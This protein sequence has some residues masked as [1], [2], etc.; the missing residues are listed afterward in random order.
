MAKRP[1]NFGPRTLR[2][3]FSGLAG[4]CARPK[5]IGKGQVPTDDAGDQKQMM[6]A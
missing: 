3:R 2:G 1:V 4:S 6:I 5:V